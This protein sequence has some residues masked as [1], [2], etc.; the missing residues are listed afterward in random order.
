MMPKV[1]V[2]NE[3]NFRPGTVD[4]D[5]FVSNAITSSGDGRHCASNKALLRVIANDFARANGAVELC[6]NEK[7]KA[8]QEPPD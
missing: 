1:R 5:A 7:T 6:S 3:W 4:R 2:R 8:L